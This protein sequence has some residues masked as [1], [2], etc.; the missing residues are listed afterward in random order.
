MQGVE[1]MFQRLTTSLTKPPLA[2]F[3]MKDSW[4]RVLLYLLLVP[5]LLMIPTWLKSTISPG[6]SVSRYE[7]LISAISTLELSDAEIVDGVLITDET[8]S[9]T[10]DY[11]QISVGNTELSA[12]KVHF[13]FLEDGLLLR[14][15]QLDLI[16]SDYTSIGLENYDF[17]DQS[18]LNVRLL[19]Q[20]IKSVYEETNVFTIAEVS[21]SYFE[22]IIDFVFYA[23]L[24]SGLMYFFT[25]HIPIPYGFRLKLSIY[26]S[27]IFVFIKLL[28]ILFNLPL[29]HYLV[30][31]VL[32]IY[33]FW[34]Y[35]SMK[36]I[37]RGITV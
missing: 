36:I 30:I 12:D 19:A 26:L 2:V 34:A 15:S 31:P 3:F 14:I 24:M 32:Y 22:G 7:R 1:G 6:M 37:D 18:A 9:A 8:S 27:T 23:F 11:Y 10:F 33:H 20:S 29:L 17:S 13:I 25:K 16:K 5:M 28:V 35:K 21:L 4:K